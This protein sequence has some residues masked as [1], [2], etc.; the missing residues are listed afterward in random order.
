MRKASW[1]ILDGDDDDE[2]KFDTG[3]R[4]NNNIE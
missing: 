3:F 2:Q 4:N 1:D